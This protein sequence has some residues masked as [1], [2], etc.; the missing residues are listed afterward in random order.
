MPESFS[1]PIRDTLISLGTQAETRELPYLLVGGNA[2][3]KYGI[4]RFT[5]DIDFLIPETS[6]GEWRSFLEGAGYHCFHATPA[7]SQFESRDTNLAP[8]DLMIVDTSTWTKLFEKAERI[9]ITDTYSPHL[10][11]AIHLIAMKLKASQNPHRRGDAQDWSDIIKLIRKLEIDIKEP[12]VSEL[13]IRY[14][15]SDALTR[16]ENSLR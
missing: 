4:A 6:L 5:R 1:N 12:E 11:A 14:G 9:G 2:V 16:L 15:G 10:P 13:I 8:V 3:I 7:F